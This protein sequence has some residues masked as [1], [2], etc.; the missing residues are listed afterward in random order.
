[1]AAEREQV[2]AHAL[3]IQTRFL[4]R[5]VTTPQIIAFGLTGGLMPC[6]AAFTVLLVCLQ[7]KQFT[8]GFAL[9]GVLMAAGSLVLD[10]RRGAIPYAPAI[11]LGAWLALL[12]EK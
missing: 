11:V 12:A 2:D 6:P 9:V 4:N 5:T 7:V 3:D 8:L 1:M 10:R